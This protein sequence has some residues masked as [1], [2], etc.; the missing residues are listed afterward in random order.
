MGSERMNAVG[1][2]L[3]DRLP[4]SHLSYEEMVAKK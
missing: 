1:A 3:R 4:L 2:F